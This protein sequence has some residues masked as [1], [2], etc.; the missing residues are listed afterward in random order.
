MDYLIAN[1]DHIQFKI[2]KELDE[3]YGALPLPF[4]GMD[5]KLNFKNKNII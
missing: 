3:Q 1:V 2:E 4:A 5:S